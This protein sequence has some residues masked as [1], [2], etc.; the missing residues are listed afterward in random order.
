MRK[1][2]A[3]A[4]LVLRKLSSVLHASLHSNYNSRT[5]LRGN[6]PLSLFV[7]GPANIHS[8]TS[9]V[10]L[11]FYPLL[12]PHL[13]RWS[14]WIFSFLP[15]HFFTRHGLKAEGRELSTQP[16]DNLPSGFLHCTVRLCQPVSHVLEQVIQEPVTQP[17][18]EGEVAITRLKGG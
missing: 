8:P 16:L 4:V 14:K 9:L 3:T 17:G 10:R 15:Q 5:P 11:S 12:H 1:R 7:S 18:P 13:L 6:Q 2:H